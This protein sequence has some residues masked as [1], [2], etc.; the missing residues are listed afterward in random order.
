MN[1]PIKITLLCMLLC[2]WP[3]ISVLHCMNS[4]STSDSISSEKES[5]KEKCPLCWDEFGEECI[6]LQF[7]CSLD[8]DGHPQPHVFCLECIREIT[9]TSTLCPLC[10]KELLLLDPLAS[11]KNIH[12]QA[13]KSDYS[14]TKVI[15]AL[16]LS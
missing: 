6:P 8:K 4:F 10:R 13:K 3:Y 16:R 2:V 1:C 14:C 11:V 15:N 7:S 5:E 12:P 9:C